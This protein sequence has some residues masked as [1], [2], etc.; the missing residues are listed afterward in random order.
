MVQFTHSLAHRQRDLAVHRTLRQVIE[1]TI[2]FHQADLRELSVS[3]ELEVERQ[4][5]ELDCQL[6]VETCLAELVRSAVAHCTS[7]GQLTVSACRTARGVEIEIADEDSLTDDAPTSAFSRGHAWSPHLNRSEPQ[8][9]GSAAALD[10]YHTRCPQ[11]G[12]AWTLVMN[13]RLAHA[14]AA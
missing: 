8:R 14:K 5:A 3:V 6:H 9:W 10:V 2:E 13:S 1:A 7:G 12:Q 4:V 11:G